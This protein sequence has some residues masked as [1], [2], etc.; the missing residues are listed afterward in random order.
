MDGR[1][2]ARLLP[3]GAALAALAALLAGCSAPE[4]SYVAS[5]DSTSFVRV[6]SEW[7]HFREAAFE[8]AVY[9]D[10][11]DGQRLAQT[12]WTVGFDA[13]AQPS[14][15]H[16]VSMSADAPAIYLTVREL[17]GTTTVTDDAMRD[18]LLPVSEEARVT[19][20]TQGS[21]FPGFEL[22]SD[23]QVD[24]GGGAH[25]VHVRYHYQVGA[26]LQTFSQKVLVNK[27][28]S[29]LYALLAH[30]SQQ[31]FTTHSEALDG[32][33]ASFTVRP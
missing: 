14:T 13:S 22:L 2:A 31:C 16:V 10:D 33:I 11:A 4:F 25:G 30:C 8:A 19:A 26:T 17:A 28:N 18:L 23:E 7:T 32:V 5:S 1:Q 9:G 27:D 20:A 24:A 6:P 12:S 3:V 29:R 21:L 15:D